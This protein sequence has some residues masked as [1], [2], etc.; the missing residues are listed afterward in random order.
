ML[1]LFSF[2]IKYEGGEIEEDAP[3]DALKALPRKRELGSS[4]DDVDEKKTA[5]KS[6]NSPS[7]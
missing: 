3:P 7:R 5:K 2:Q 6:K 1:T 4:S